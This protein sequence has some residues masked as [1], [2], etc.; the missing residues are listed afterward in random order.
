LAAILLVMMLAFIAFAVDLGYLALV[1]TQLQSAADSAALASTVDLLEN[2]LRTTPVSSSE[3]EGI[4]RSSAQYC[5]ASNVIAGSTLNTLADGDI[6][7]GRISLGAGSN[8]A[9]TFD[10][11]S[12][13]N[14]TQVVARRSA[15]Q[16]GEVPMFFARALGIDSRGSRATATAAYADNFQ[17]FKPPS[18]GDSNL[19]ILPFTLDKQTWDQL[20][21]GQ[22]AD[23]WAWTPSTKRIGNGS[24]GIREANMYPQGTGSP[25]N[26]GTVDIGNPNNSTRD[27]GRQIRD[28]VS[29]E[30]LSYVPGGSLVPGDSG[31]IQ[32]TGDTGMSVGIKNDLAAII[33]ETRVIPIFSRV[34]GNGNNATYTIVQFVGV[35]VMAVNLTGNPGDRHVIVQPA[36]MQID[37]GVPA[38]DG[39]QFSQFLFSKN[40]W[41]VH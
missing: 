35:R 5:M 33:G 39:T 3:I 25:G 36:N 18:E 32:L 41:L 11:P 9:M 13:F 6:T 34:G 8:G 19:P 22:T 40:V 2:R 10:D 38:P 31:T 37:N 21:A 28:G 30:D 26:R 23:N 14:A 27:L 12:R 1:R 15:A 20:L 24:D 17:G 16:N 4:A 7:L 29:A